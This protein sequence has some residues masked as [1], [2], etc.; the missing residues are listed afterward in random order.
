M[1][2]ACAEFVDIGPFRFECAGHLP[3]VRQWARR[4]QNGRLRH[5]SALTP[6]DDGDVEVAWWTDA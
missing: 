1:M 6:R 4:Y 5:D 2:E 3:G